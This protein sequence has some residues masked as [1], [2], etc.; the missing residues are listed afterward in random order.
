MRREVPLPV[1]LVVIVVVILLVV[2]VGWFLM[3]RQ[4]KEVGPPPRE[5]MGKPPY[6]TPGGK[7]V[8]PGQGGPAKG[9]PF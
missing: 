8:Q 2:G 5:Y 4:P 1:A 3:T 7:A 9:Q 6:A